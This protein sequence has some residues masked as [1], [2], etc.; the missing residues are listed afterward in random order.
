MGSALSSPA[1]LLGV[2]IFSVR[3]LLD[4]MPNTANLELPSRR[5]RVDLPVWCFIISIQVLLLVGV[6]DLCQY[7]VFNLG[8]LP[9]SINRPFVGQAITNTEMGTALICF[10]K[11]SDNHLICFRSQPA[12]RNAQEED[13]CRELG[14]WLKSLILL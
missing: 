14:L 12:R 11:T 2:E 8:Y 4:G 10:L 7:Y 5:C 6:I 9:S 13:H 1:L 3:S